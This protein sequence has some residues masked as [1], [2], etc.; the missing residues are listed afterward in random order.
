M[1]YWVHL[2]MFTVILILVALIGWNMYVV[3]KKGRKNGNP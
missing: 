3:F 1:S 2:G